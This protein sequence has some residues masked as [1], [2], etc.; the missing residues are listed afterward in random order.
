MSTNSIFVI[1]L[2][3]PTRDCHWH[4][5]SESS[6][7]ERE[8]KTDTSKEKL[9]DLLK[10]R[11]QRRRN[12]SFHVVGLCALFALYLGPT[13][14]RKIKSQVF[15]WT[16]KWHSF[17]LKSVDQ[18][19]KRNYHVLNIQRN[20]DHWTEWSRIEQSNMVASRYMWFLKFKL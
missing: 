1:A 11:L 15:P 10:S 5:I 16:G 9:S 20:Q 17:Y 8:P 12:C 4:Q 2:A 13:G 19:K 14:R 3:L 18:K 6:T 7:E